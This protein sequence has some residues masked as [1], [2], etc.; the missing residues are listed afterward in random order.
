MRQSLVQ[1]CAENR[2]CQRSHCKKFFATKKV[3]YEKIYLDINTS[4]VVHHNGC[5]CRLRA[6]QTTRVSKQ[7]RNLRQMHKSSLCRGRLCRQVPRSCTCTHLRERLPH[8]QQMFGYN[9]YGKCLR[10]KVSW[11][12]NTTQLSKQMRNL[13]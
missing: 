5:A 8:L 3:N 12:H 10:R 11:S 13:R 2:S 7:V 6:T 9:L 4:C 1:S